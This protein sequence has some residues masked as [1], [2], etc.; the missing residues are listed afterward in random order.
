M[1]HL[2]WHFITPSPLEM[3]VWEHGAAEICVHVTGNV[4]KRYDCWWLLMIVERWLELAYDGC[5]IN[6]LQPHRSYRLH[7]RNCAGRT[8]AGDAFYHSDDA[9]CRLVT[10]ALELWPR[11]LPHRHG[12]S[13]PS[14]VLR[15]P[16]ADRRFFLRPAAEPMTFRPTAAATSAPPFFLRGSA[17]RRQSDTD[18][19]ERRSSE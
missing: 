3:V 12:A 2:T 17:T 9:Y 10:S 4:W 5:F 19:P 16:C 7:T 18:P 15:S 11:R 1:S 8:L 13:S 6:T 14:F